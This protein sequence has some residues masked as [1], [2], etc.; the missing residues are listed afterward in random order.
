M[1]LRPY[2]LYGWGLDTPES[3]M[4]REPKS[5]REV[6]ARA[7]CRMEGHPEDILFQG[8]PMWQSFLAHVDAV[9]EAAL[10]VEEWERMKAEGPQ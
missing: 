7:L 10:S 1:C 4:P 8:S 6:A 5:P 3:L 9:L 2:L